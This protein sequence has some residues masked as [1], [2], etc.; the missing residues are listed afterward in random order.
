[1]PYGDLLFTSTVTDGSI[2]GASF[3]SV[4]EI[5]RTCTGTMYLYQGYVQH[6]N[7]TLVAESVVSRHNFGGEH[8]Y[9]RLE[10]RDPFQ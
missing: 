9:Y 7:K 5:P 6:E 1:M 2:R 4:F 3:A 8:T 10:T